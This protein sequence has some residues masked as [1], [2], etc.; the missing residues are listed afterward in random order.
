M[1]GWAEDG[2]GPSRIG[3][4]GADRGLMEI[5]PPGLVDYIILWVIM[6]AWIMYIVMAALLAGLN[7]S[8]SSTFRYISPRNKGRCVTSIM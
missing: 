8:F 2:S 4:L 1:S 5:L 3:C 6:M 7:P